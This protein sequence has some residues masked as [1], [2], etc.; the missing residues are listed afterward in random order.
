MTADAVLMALH[1]QID[2]EIA[3]YVRL[4]LARGDAVQGLWYID[5]KGKLGTPKMT[6]TVAAKECKT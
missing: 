5:A 2:A 4:A 3:P 1:R 6:A